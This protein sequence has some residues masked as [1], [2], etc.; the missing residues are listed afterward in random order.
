MTRTTFGMRS[1]LEVNGLFGELSLMKLKNRIS[2]SFSNVLRNSFIG[3]NFIHLSSSFYSL[4]FRMFLSLF[5]FYTDIQ[6]TFLR[7]CPSSWRQGLHCSGAPGARP[8]RRRSGK[9]YHVL[10]G[11]TTK[12]SKQWPCHHHVTISIHFQPH[13]QHSWKGKVWIWSIHDFRVIAGVYTCNPFP[14][15]C[16]YED[17][18]HHVFVP[19]PE[20]PGCITRILPRREGICAPPQKQKGC[21]LQQLLMNKILQQPGRLKN[22]TVYYT[23][24]NVYCCY[25]NW[26]R[27][28]FIKIT[29]L[30]LPYLRI[31]TS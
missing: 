12:S 17:W 10:E 3:F 24:C 8:V 5:L 2:Q 13:L 7:I 20:L 29:W 14:A 21:N 18:A 15:Y 1:T 11:S 25:I 28:L 19:K 4:D 6:C 9:R 30:Q 16:N 22:Y 31:Q 27:I 23:E 26:C